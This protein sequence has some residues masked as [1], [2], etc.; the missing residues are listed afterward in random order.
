SKYGIVTKSVRLQQVFRSQTI[1]HSPALLRIIAIDPNGTTNRRGHI[2]YIEPGNQMKY[3]Y[4]LQNFQ[5]L[6]KMRLLQIKI[7]TEHAAVI[8]VVL[9]FVPWIPT[10]GGIVN[11]V[12]GGLI[13]GIFLPG[14]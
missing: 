8:P 11:K 5:R 2:A 13:Q 7:I 12:Q 10:I 9:L 3:R 6:K 14:R 1:R 4:I